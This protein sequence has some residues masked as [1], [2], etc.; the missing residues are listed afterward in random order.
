MRYANE[1]LRAGPQSILPPCKSYLRASAQDNNILNKV[2]D[3]IAQDGIRF[4]RFLWMNGT[5]TSTFSARLCF[6]LVSIGLIAVAIYLGRS[7]LIPLFFSILLALILSPITNFLMRKEMDRFLAIL[8]PVVLGLLII[9]LLV[10]FLSFQI[11]LFFND[12]P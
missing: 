3:Q 4:Y 7:I 1:A 9:G 10:Y 11:S 6:T 2:V 5:Y 8:V 12:I